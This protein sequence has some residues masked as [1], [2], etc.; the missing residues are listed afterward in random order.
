M[1]VSLSNLLH[2]TG[3]KNTAGNKVK[4]FFALYDDVDVLPK[5]AD[6]PTSFEAIPVIAGDITFKTGKQFF[7]LYVTVE[8]GV[9]TCNLVGEDDG[10]SFENQYSGFH[11]GNSKSFTGFS[12]YMANQ[13][14]IFLIEDNEGQF[15][16][17]G[18]DC[19]PAKLSSIEATTGAAISD[20][21]GS[22]FTIMSKGD[23]APIYEGAIA[24]TPAT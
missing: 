2:S 19:Y 14:G 18:N 12:A 7:E 8:T 11:P 1:S 3:A 23:I 10:K 9:L 22:T 15:R 24:L 4:I 5:I 16:L 21:K 6:A 20:R 17:L 13:N